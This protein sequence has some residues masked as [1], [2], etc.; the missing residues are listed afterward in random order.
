MNQQNGSEKK[1]KILQHIF[2]HGALALTKITNVSEIRLNLFFCVRK[3]I[4]IA[5]VHIM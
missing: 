1:K 3:H 5:L 4:S 2:K